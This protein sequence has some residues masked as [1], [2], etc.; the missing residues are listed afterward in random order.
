LYNLEHEEGVTKHKPEARRATMKHQTA[1]L[2]AARM[3]DAQDRLA[4]FKAAQ[5]ARRSWV[6][7]AL[8]AL[9]Q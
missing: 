1:E 5:W 9:F 7:R 3:L 6:S 8:W 4:A 2:A